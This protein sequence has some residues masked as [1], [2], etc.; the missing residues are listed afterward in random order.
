[1]KR[2]ARRPATQVMMLKVSLR[3]VIASDLP[4]F[5]E[6]QRDP[7]AVHM[8]AFTMKDP[9]DRAA[10]DAHWARLLVDDSVIMRTIIVDGG[11]AGSVSS[12]VGDSGPEVTY[13]LGRDYWGRG[14]ATAALVEFLK[15]QTT[16][17]IFAR[18]AADNLAS[19]RVLQKCGFIIT[20]RDQGFANARDRIIDE[21]LLELGGADTAG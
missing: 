1:M 21:Y 12:Y 14:I 9:D 11:V 17:P 10:F 18:A 5:F 3:Q 15:V 16:R 8:A 7:A 20:G 4:A 19:L 2:R 6:Q 13:W